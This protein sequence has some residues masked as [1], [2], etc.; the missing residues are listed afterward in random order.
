MDRDV[1]RDAYLRE[2]VVS[3]AEDTFPDDV[4]LSW[5]I[6]AIEHRGVWSAVTTEPSGEVGYPG[7]VF[8]VSFADESMPRPIATYARMGPGYELLCTS[9][10]V[11][12]R[13]IPPRWPPP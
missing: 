5:R 12:P 8:L 7:F 3:I 11:N 6:L 10:G 2:N 13:E 4:G 1:D 9:Q